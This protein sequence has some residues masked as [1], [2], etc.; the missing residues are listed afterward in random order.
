MPYTDPQRQRAA[1]RESAR[2]R[3]LA[4]AEGVSNRNPS[5]PNPTPGPLLS[6]ELR[7]DT[8]QDVLRLIETQVVAVLGHET[9]ATGE[10]ARVVVSLA[11]TAL[12]AIDAGNLAARIEALEGVLGTR[13]AA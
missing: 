5:N 2:R 10:R 7:L 3:R 11:N 9:L 13:S 4:R 1:Q 8:A 6:G 12:R